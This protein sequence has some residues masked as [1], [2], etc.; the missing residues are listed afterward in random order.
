MM[1]PEIIMV[2]MLYLAAV[3]AT[4]RLKRLPH[5][6]QDCSEAL[7]HMLNHVIRPYA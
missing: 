5:L 1:V 6:D 4:F 2:V 7:Q 3:S